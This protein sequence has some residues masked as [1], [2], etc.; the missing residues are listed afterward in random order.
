MCRPLHLSQY[1][2]HD[3]MAMPIGLRPVGSCCVR[4]MKGGNGKKWV[5]RATETEEGY[6]ETGASRELLGGVEPQRLF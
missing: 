6:E 4:C 1:L 2:R 5:L 3:V